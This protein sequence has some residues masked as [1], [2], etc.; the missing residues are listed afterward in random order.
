VQNI[1]GKDVTEAANGFDQ[2]RLMRV[3][4]D[5]TPQA[6]EKTSSLSTSCS[7]SQTV[8]SS[9]T[10]RIAGFIVCFRQGIMLSLIFSANGSSQMHYCVTEFQAMSHP[11]PL[12]HVNFD[13][14]LFLVRVLTKKGP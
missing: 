8:V 3:N 11:L 14:C 2:Q 7:S 6:H 10:T 9:S 13:D 4:F 5:F 12:R 1:G